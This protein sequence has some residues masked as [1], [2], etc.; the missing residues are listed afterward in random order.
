[1][2]VLQTLMRIMCLLSSVSGGSLLRLCPDA[3]AAFRCL[4]AA[5]FL[6]VSSL[7][8]PLSRM[9]VMSKVA[10]DQRNRSDAET[11]G[12]GDLG[13]SG[14]ACIEEAFAALREVSVRGLSLSDLR[15]LSA[16]LG[17]LRNRVA[18]LLC[19]VSR[20]VREVEPTVS[21]SEVLKNSV[22]LSG[23]DAR[24]LA[25]VGEAVAE[26]PRVAQKLEDGEISLD[27]AVALVSAAEDCG[28]D[29]V[30]G[31]A[32][33]LD[34][35]VRTPVDRFI[36]EAREFASRRSED[37]GEGRLE[38]QRK[39]R[40]AALF[41]DS[42]S[43]MGVL[44]GE[45]DPVGFNLLQQAVDLYTDTLWRR[46]G[47][48]GAQT[49]AVR[50]PEQ[51]RADAIFEMITGK[52]A[53]TH[54]ALP[55]VD[56]GTPPGRTIAGAQLVV[57]A[58]IGVIDGT[59]PDGRCEIVGTGSV[60]PAFLRT[61]SPDTELSG[62][63]FGREGRPLWLGRRQRL[64]NISQR[65]VLA[66]RDGGCVLCDEPMHRCEIHHIR[67]WNTEG[68]S[69]D[70]DN[71]VTLC[72]R[73][74]RWLHNHNRT[75]S[76][77]P[78][79]GWVS[80]SRSSPGSEAASG[81]EAV[82]SV[83]RSAQEASQSSLGPS[84]FETSRR[85]SGVGCA[86]V[87]RSSPIDAGDARRR[88]RGRDVGRETCDSTN[89]TPEDRGERGLRSFVGSGGGRSPE[90]SLSPCSWSRQRNCLQV[91]V[92][93]CSSVG[94]EGA[95]RSGTFRELSFVL[96]RSSVGS[97]GRS[98]RIRERLPDWSV[99]ECS[100]VGSEGALRSGTFRELS[101]VLGRSSV[102]SEGRLDWIR[103]RL[104]DWSVGGCSSVGSEGALRSGTFR[105][106]SFV[107]GRSSS[108]VN[109]DRPP[110][111]LRAIWQGRLLR[112]VPR[113]TTVD[114]RSGWGRAVLIPAVACSIWRKRGDGGC[115]WGRAVLIPAIACS[116]WRKR[117]DGGCGWG[118]AVSTSEVPEYC[119]F[120][121]EGQRGRCRQ[122]L[123]EDC[124][125]LRAR[126]GDRL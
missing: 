78:G 12:S 125:L 7:S 121:G 79:K 64:A 60:P 43:G 53:A 35:A 36:K 28:A 75:L 44:H 115:G 107:L 5:P 111:G 23:R 85:G 47:G 54:E 33:L 82:P 72:G 94:S 26:M 65:L 119:T 91:S 9:D 108:L 110:W 62:A 61:L 98:D 31:D 69:T 10:V 86:A 24:R 18:S 84:G 29:V 88:Q 81:V 50:T 38:R 96:G 122:D 49:D 55:I 51:R 4:V 34:R 114:S 3:D 41:S 104:P 15:V 22:G 113:S 109:G 100:S 48:R 117:G 16:S 99:G 105:E 74:H 59:R 123:L 83:G 63:I 32:D 56:D 14:V 20:E 40:K 13:V 89:S 93:E 19:D 2:T 45:Y 95:L 66:V 27:H 116:I 21:T 102:G 42:D 77:S 58:D 70:I 106:L 25:K 87:S 46:D 118:R 76:Y 37:Q 30:D 71:L 90:P 73:H 6:V 112:R 68:G 126:R 92:G 1:M 101:F 80:R 17:R 124:R 103:E 97:E 8:H 39:S 57:V 67:E 52:D 120:N 11:L